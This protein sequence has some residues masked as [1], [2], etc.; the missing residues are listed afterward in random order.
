MT[1]WILPV[2]LALRVGAKANVPFVRGH[3]KIKCAVG[4]NFKNICR[5]VSCKIALLV[6]VEIQR[7]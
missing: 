5:L 4:K 7:N 2:D 6:F 1:L 3:S